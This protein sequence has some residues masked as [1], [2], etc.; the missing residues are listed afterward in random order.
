MLLDRVEME[1]YLLSD[2]E[3]QTVELTPS[4]AEVLYHGKKV[5]ILV[6]RDPEEKTAT[7]VELTGQAAELMDALKELRNK[8]AKEAGIPPYVIFSN[9][10][11]T[12]MAKKQ[13]KNLTEFR[14]VSGVGE[15]KAAWYGKAFLKRI[16][17]F[18]EENE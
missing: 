12:D 14:R 13:P 2:P 17:Q 10:T 15:L 4:A 8:L 1:G 6:R 3:N 11:L 5:E 7:A 9:A 18:R 16:R